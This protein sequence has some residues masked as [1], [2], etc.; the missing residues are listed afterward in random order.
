MSL[1][2]NKSPLGDLGVALKK[3]AFETASLGGVDK[4]GG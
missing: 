1:V 2:F 4:E 3:E